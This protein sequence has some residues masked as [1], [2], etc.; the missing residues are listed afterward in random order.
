MIATSLLYVI[1][2][3]GY[4]RVGKSDLSFCSSHHQEKEGISHPLKALYH[5]QEM[6]KLLCDSC[7]LEEQTGLPLQQIQG[8]DVL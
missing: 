7:G 6:W 2:I 3:V 8:N 1:V 4:G 5:Y